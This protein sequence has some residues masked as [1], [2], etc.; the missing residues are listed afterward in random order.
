M[1]LRMRSLVV[2]GIVGMLF[3]ALGVGAVLA[4]GGSEVDDKK[5]SGHGT[6][7]G[8]GV[9]REKA[10]SWDEGR[11]A[12]AGALGVTVEDLDAAARQVALDRVDEA[13]E[14]GK[15]TEEEAAEIRTRVESSEAGDWHPRGR[16][17]GLS[18]GGEALAEALGV[19]V[20]DLKAAM[21]QVLLDRIDAAVK[22]GKVSEEKAEE[23]RTAIESGDKPER[24]GDSRGRWRG[25]RGHWGPGDKDAATTD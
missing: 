14:A 13:V 16:G 6:G 24:D 15:I 5:R 12:F 1:S 23:W 17:F 7:A 8:Y 18:A 25:S 3:A 10:S 9:D 21:R 11:E 2:A 19:T 22:T 4:E 20:E